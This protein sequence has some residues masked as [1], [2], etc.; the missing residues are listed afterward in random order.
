MILSLSG[1]HLPVVISSNLYNHS[2]RETLL[3]MAISSSK[4]NKLD[5][6]LGLQNW[7]ASGLL[8]PSIFKSSIATI[9]NSYILAKVGSLSDVDI[10]S[11]DKMIDEIC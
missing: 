4:E 3:I 11:L 7:K 5:F 10:A 2:M 8:K 1:F 6:E 9:E